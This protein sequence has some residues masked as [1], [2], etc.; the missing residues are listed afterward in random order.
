MRWDKKPIDAREVK[1][2]SERYGVDLLPSAVFV[3][4]GITDPAQLQFFLEDDPRFLHNP[5][6]FNEMTD[7]VMR[8]SQAETEGE[9]VH[10][11]G[12]RD[13]DG[14]TSTVLMTEA[15]QRLGIEVSWGVP[16]GDE[17]YGITQELIDDLA[18]R[19]VTLLIAVDC[20]T[21]NSSEIAYASDLG[22]DTIVVDHHNPQG[23]TPPA[24]AI[25]NPKMPDESY[26]FQGL[27]ACGLVSKLCYALGFSKTDFFNETICLLNAK[28]GN[29]SVILEAIK[30]E[31]MIEVDRITE[32]LV[33]GVVDVEHSRLGS[34][35]QGL[36][37]LVFDEAGQARLL[38]EA[39]GAGV[40]INVIDV[41]PEIR[42]MFPSIADRS[43]LR[44]KS[45]SRLGRYSGQQ[46]GEIDAY[47]SLFTTYV[48]RREESILD[49]LLASLD[50]V[51]LATLADMMPLRD[52]N[53]ILVK[54]GLKRMS[55]SP[56]NGLRELMDRQR[57][58]GKTI[59]ARDIGWSL[60]P[61]IN[62]SGRMGEPDRAVKLFIEPDGSARVRHADE[63]L[64][65][66]AK[67]KET[68]EGAW[69]LVQV[70]AQQ[71]LER[72]SGRFLYV[73][74]EQIHRGIT[75]LLAGRLARQFDAPATVLSLLPGK[76]VGSVRTARGFVVTDFLARCGDL[77][78]DWGG[79]DQAGGFT[80][81]LDRVGELENRIHEIVPALR[82]GEEEVESILIDA[83]LPKD[84][85]NAKIMDVVRRFAPFGQ[86]HPPLAFL[87]RGIAI[88][89]IKFMGKDQSHLRL[90]L[91]AGAT[92]WPSVYWRAADKVGSEF[93]E[94]DVVDA[95][96]HV[97]SN[98]YQ[99]VESPQ[100]TV[101]DLARSG[102]RSA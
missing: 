16:M 11:F 44:L 52:E 65:L 91:D 19:D 22:I 46:P 8:I 4:R 59:V 24:V 54:H 72:Y 88:R 5:F 39:F 58:L 82:I 49:E 38:R 6:L 68:G 93:G 77:L 20:G 101:L 79:H 95:V 18:A 32:N 98:F 70:Q 45:E 71:S 78:L 57:L 7:A 3:R 13:V 66:N 27:C 75:G 50:L 26:P 92:K 102:A 36:P 90:T 69:D 12:D 34:F 37:L 10:V 60:S 56:R 80:V 73:K 76:G 89:E 35:L 96:V 1:A 62:S 31:N 94:G 48:H 67:R 41:A 86:E 83:E 87:V 33:P 2:F 30:L 100:L 84:M 55:S 14:V 63:L 21:S 42:K 85:L 40:D 81:Q 17:S 53:R 97:G 64:A 61:V 15:L 47:L 99:G 74:H 28:P 23:E 25:I 51:A 29:D 9:R 43:L